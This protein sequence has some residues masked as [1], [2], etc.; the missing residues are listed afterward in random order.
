MLCSL[1]Q[2]NS[3]VA[4]SKRKVKPANFLHNT[5]LPT[6][7]SV[8]YWSLNL[9][10][11]APCSSIFFLEIQSSYPASYKINKRQTRNTRSRGKF[12]P[13]NMLAGRVFWTQIKPRTVFKVNLLFY[14]CCWFVEE[15][16]G[17]RLSAARASFSP[18]GK[19]TLNGQFNLSLNP[20]AI[21]SFA[22][23]PLNVYFFQS[24]NKA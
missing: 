13:L 12:C 5:S 24:R 14:P 6:A 16:L 10:M 18:L 15:S 21:K 23:T 3:E 17:S 4:C 7:N 19:P 8:T 2:W 22:W 9:A 1:K 20:N 11:K